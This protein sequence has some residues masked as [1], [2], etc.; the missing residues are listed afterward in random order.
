MVISCFLMLKF[1]GLSLK[2]CVNASFN[3]NIKT[4]KQSDVFV[5]LIYVT[6][7]S[8]GSSSQ[9][10]IQLH[11]ICNSLNNHSDSLNGNPFSSS[12]VICKRYCISVLMS[13]N[14]VVFM[15]LY[16]LKHLSQTK[17]CS[18]IS[19]LVWCLTLNKAESIVCS[20]ES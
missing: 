16:I 14:S 2:M 15:N 20:V 18:T 5:Y 3:N 7:H 1:I 8:P 9:K 19:E 13:P 12:F 4:M 17:Y 10:I 11:P 6:M